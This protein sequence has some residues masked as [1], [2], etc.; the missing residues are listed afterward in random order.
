MRRSDLVLLVIVGIL[1]FFFLRPL[2]NLG[3]GLLI[4]VLVW[5]FVGFLAGQIMGGRFGPVGN[6]LLGLIGG[7]VGAAVLGLV[8]LNV[9]GILGYLISGTLGAVLVIAVL[10]ALRVRL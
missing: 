9:G 1:A 3:I 8:G 4:I 2:L 6:V 5:A 7:I 10:R